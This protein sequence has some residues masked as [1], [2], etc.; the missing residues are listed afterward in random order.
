[1]IFSYASVAQQVEH[2]AVNQ[3]VE[4]SS[5]VFSFPKE[6]SSTSKEREISASQIYYLHIFGFE[7]PS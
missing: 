1:M 4:G 3:E 7:N 6:K 5:E 2:L